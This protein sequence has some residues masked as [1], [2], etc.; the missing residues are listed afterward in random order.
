[1]D[2]TFKLI[3]EVNAENTEI[4][5]NNDQRVFYIHEIHTSI[6]GQGGL[7]PPRPPM[8]ACVGCFCLYIFI[9]M[10]IYLITCLIDTSIYVSIVFVLTDS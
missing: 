1:M 7:R 6:G 2:Q 5:N 4:D 8:L 10:I 9:M 3:K